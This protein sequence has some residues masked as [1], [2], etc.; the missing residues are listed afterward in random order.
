M[1]SS[2]ET[3]W[4]GAQGIASGSHASCLFCPPFNIIRVP[5]LTV[6]VCQQPLI[7]LWSERR[8]ASGRIGESG[9]LRVQEWMIALVLIVPFAVVLAASAFPHIASGAMGMSFVVAMKMFSYHLVNRDLRRVQDSQHGVVREQVQGV[10]S[11][12]VYPE[13][14]TVGNLV[15]FLAAPTLW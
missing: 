9:N 3:A 5:S 8:L 7:M 12:V 13:N 2:G 10:E 6:I 15:Y 4:V 11:P 1:Y 14:L